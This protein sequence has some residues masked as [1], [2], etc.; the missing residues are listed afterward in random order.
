MTSQAL[1]ALDVHGSGRAFHSAVT[2]RQNLSPAAVMAITC[3]NPEVSLT[4]ISMP[5]ARLPETSH[6]PRHCYEQKIFLCTT[7]IEL[8]FTIPCF[9]HLSISGFGWGYLMTGKGVWLL[10][11]Q[12]C[13][14]CSQG[15]TGSVRQQLITYVCN[16]RVAG[17][18]K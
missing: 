7:K 12:M 3:A 6:R 15:V 8:M 2:T 11:S 4:V 10:D 9:S 16:N 17:L 5:V 1:G 13:V 14:V 18:S